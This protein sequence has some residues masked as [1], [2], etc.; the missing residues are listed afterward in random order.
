MTRWLRKLQ[1]ILPYRTYDNIWKIATGQNDDYATRCLLG[2]PH[3]KEYYKLVAMDLSKQQEL[4]ADLKAIQK[5][6][7]IWNLNRAEWRQF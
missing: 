6:N 5:D 7:F 4:D 2:Y 3:F 1:A